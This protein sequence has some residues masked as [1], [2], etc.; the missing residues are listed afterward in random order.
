MKNLP[1]KP[2]IKAYIATSN[3]IYHKALQAL[4]SVNRQLIAEDEANKADIILLDADD[5]I[6]TQWQKERIFRINFPVRPGI[7]WQE[8]NAAVHKANNIIA[9]EIALPDRCVYPKRR[10]VLVENKNSV[11]LTEKERDI[12]TY[13]ASCTSFESSRNDILKNVW[14][15]VEGIETHTLE[16]HIYRLRQKIEK[17]ASEPQNLVTTDIGYKLHV[18]EIK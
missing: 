3:P 9:D 6:D 8:I 11:S 12:L 14:G 4:L 2:S 17:N 7:L 13:L 18:T 16:T 15:Y 10:E 5:Q 1:Q